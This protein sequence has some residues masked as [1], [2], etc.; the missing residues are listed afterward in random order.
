MDKNQ[1]TGRLNEAKGKIKEET[2]KV[3]GNKNLENKGNIEKNVG[4]A[5]AKYGDIKSDIK[6]D[7]E[8]DRKH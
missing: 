3:F 8:D 1:V 5:Q 6:K 2:G 4:K 7:I